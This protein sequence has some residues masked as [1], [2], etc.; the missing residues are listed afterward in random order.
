MFL[1]PP[2]IP[3][4]ESL[5]QSTISSLSSGSFGRN[6]YDMNIQQQNI[7]EVA[8][9]ETLMADNEELDPQ[10][11]QYIYNVFSAADLSSISSSDSA[12]YKSA[13]IKAKAIHSFV[14]ICW[15]MSRHIQ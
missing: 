8:D 2:P 4:I 13:W 11:P 9:T 3:N 1:S 14:F 5:S 6:I 15:V 12:K 7:S 10:P